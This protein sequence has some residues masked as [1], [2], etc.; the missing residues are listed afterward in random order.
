MTVIQP[1][2]IFCLRELTAKISGVYHQPPSIHRKQKSLISRISGEGKDF[3]RLL[4]NVFG[5]AERLNALDSHHLDHNVIGITSNC[6]W[7]NYHR[8]LALFLFDI[9]KVSRDKFICK[10]SR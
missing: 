6:A 5:V 10:V 8:D 3:L 7:I 4:V 2:L 1:S 9:E